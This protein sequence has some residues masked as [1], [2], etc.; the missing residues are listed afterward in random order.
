[1]DCIGSLPGMTSA[2]NSVVFCFCDEAEDISIGQPLYEGLL[3][4]LEPKEGYILPK[5]FLPFD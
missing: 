2:I 4:Q 5:L 1:M 3:P